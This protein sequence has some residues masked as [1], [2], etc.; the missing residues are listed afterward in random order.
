[1]TEDEIVGWHHRF[2]GHEFATILPSDKFLE[3]QLQLIL[4]ISLNVTNIIC[5]LEEKA[6]KLII[7]LI[8][9]SL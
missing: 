5:N 3:T 4:K 7:S 9:I 8:F 6:L 2:S 1:M